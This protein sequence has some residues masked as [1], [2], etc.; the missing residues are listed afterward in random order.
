VAPPAPPGCGTA[1]LTSHENS[2]PTAIPTGPALVTSTIEVAGASAYLA[3]LDL[4]TNLTHAFSA[5]LDITLRSPAG[6]ITTITTDNAGGNDNV[7][8]GTTFDDQANPAG[9]VPYTANNGVVT[10]TLYANNQ[11][12]TPLVPEEA[13]AAFNGENPNGT[14][15]LTISDDLAG[16]G[17]TLESWRLDIQSLS[18]APEASATSYANSTPT[19][20]PTSVA[21]VTSTI[22]VAGAGAHLAD[23]DL[24]TNLTHTYSTDLDITLQ[25]PAGT[26]TTITTDNGLGHDN[27]F[28]GTT[29]DDR[30]N[31]AGQVPFTS[32]NGVVTDT[33]YANNQTATP[34]VPEEALAA[35]NGENPNGTWTLTI[36]DDLAG[37][38]GQVD[39]S[40]DLTTAAC[41]PPPEPPVEPPPP[42]PATTGNPP[43][44]ATTGNPAP[45]PA[46]GTLQVQAD[47]LSVFAPVAGARCLGANGA[48]HVR[49]LAGRRVIAR[50]TANAMNVPP[51]LNRSG[52]KLLKARF[53]GV[54][55]TVVATDA[56]SSA[57]TRTRAIL[58]VERITTPPGSWVA[59][60]AELTAAGRR[61]VRSLRARMVGVTGLR[62]DGHVAR[63]EVESR[64]EL[65]TALSRARA[66]VVCGKEAKLVAHGYKNPIA[67]NARAKGRARNSR[68]EI[69]VRHTQA[70][71]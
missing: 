42:P 45:Q 40:L 68:V 56:A 22:Q 33:L 12:A 55:A 49:V 1:V 7:F 69:T 63:P 38:G 10:D 17:G 65:A 52:R 14:W 53:G 32:N 8:A 29:F 26:I 67:S 9:Q 23:L 58:P 46:G 13:L 27:V 43:P 3:D 25:S 71:P 19:A 15:T 70:K 2:T 36:S 11:T 61:F 48:C 59:G 35:F 44:P 20:I 21:V 34:L 30:A 24:L 57:R 6:T 4:F 50:G 5:D 47:R 37:D 16:D 28:A 54:R 41:A 64:S 39:W 31:P 66:A 51:R 62:C 18:G 60:R